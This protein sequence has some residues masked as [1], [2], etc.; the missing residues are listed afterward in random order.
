MDTYTTLDDTILDLTALTGEERAYFDHCYAAYRTGVTWSALSDLIA[1]EGNPLV[2]RAG[3]RITRAVWEHPLYQALRDLEDR[4]GIQQGCVQPEP[5]DDPARDPLADEWISASEAATRK[6]VTL[7]GL[8]RAIGRGE[9][10]ARPAKPGGSRLAV[11]VKS[12]SRW[13]PNP[14]RQAAGRKATAAKR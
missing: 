10:I 8:H 6:G 9:V 2:R 5:G 3:G 14:L 13:T 1:G 7:Q 11:S 4:L 12:L